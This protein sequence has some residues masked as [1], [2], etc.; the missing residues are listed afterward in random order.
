MVILSGPFLPAT[1][2]T[3]AHRRRPVNSDVGPSTLWTH[4]HSCP[5]LFQCHLACYPGIALGPSGRTLT[6]LSRT[7]NQRRNA[8][9]RASRTS[10][11]VQGWAP[12]PDS[13]V[14]RLAF[15][16]CVNCSTIWTLPASSSVQCSSNFARQISTTDHA[17]DPLG[18]PS[19]CRPC[20][21]SIEPPPT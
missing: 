16:R 13:S 5:V 10:M 14:S 1:L 18:Y 6:D 7:R 8:D 12:S 19:S 21:L 2:S 4:E 20:F 15:S 17:R 9:R 3:T 11:L